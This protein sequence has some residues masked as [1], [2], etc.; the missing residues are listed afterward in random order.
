MFTYHISILTACIEKWAQRHDSDL[1]M[2]SCPQCHCSTSLPNSQLKDLSKNFIALD[3]VE[4]ASARKERTPSNSASNS[5]DQFEEIFC[6]AGCSGNV[7]SL[8]IFHC[9]DCNVFMCAD[10]NNSIHFEAPVEKKHDV[11]SLIRMQRSPQKS[12]SK[13]LLRSN[14][15]T[16]TYSC[17]VHHKPMEVLCMSDNRIICTSCHFHGDHKGHECVLI[18]EMAK[19]KREAMQGLREELNTRHS[20]CVTGL[21]LCKRTKEDITRRKVQ[22]KEELDN[23]FEFLHLALE[24]RRKNIEVDMIEQLEQNLKLLSMQCRFA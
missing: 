16:S 15:D 18:D 19:I 5:F 24:G 23:Q 20:Q 6:K 14:S 3:A 2:I 12:N 4:L 11:K 13:M 17:K 1:K 8:A 21:N 9:T 10:C 7:Q 22:L